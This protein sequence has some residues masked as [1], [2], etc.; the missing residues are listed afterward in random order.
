MLLQENN[1]CK[2]AVKRLM[3]AARFTFT[4]EDCLYSLGHC[5]SLCN[6]SQVST[7]EVLLQLVVLIHLQ[8]NL[9]QTMWQC[10]QIPMRSM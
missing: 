4:A 10:L 8:L 6:H 1:I 2:T 7:S 9:A 5:F 3:Q